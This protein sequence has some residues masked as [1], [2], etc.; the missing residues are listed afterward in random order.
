M[1]YL[2]LSLALAAGLLLAQ[3]KGKDQAKQP[4]PDTSQDDSGG[5]FKNK[6][7]YKSSKQTADSTTLGFNG[8]DP[9]GKLNQDVLA[10]DASAADTAA[11]ARMAQ[12]RPN[13][14]A[15]KQFVKA[16]GLN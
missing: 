10:K 8:V 13:A 6:S 9:S 1:R 14:A 5:L 7:G 16:G 12:Q 2:S 3:Q 11:V 4:Q 15:V